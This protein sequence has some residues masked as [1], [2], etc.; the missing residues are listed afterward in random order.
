VPTSARRA[1]LKTSGGGGFVERYE[2][3]TASPDLPV[4]RQW[5]ERNPGARARL[6][7]TTE[8]GGG[9]VVLVISIPDHAEM[10]RARTEI[11][12]LVQFPE[13]LRFRR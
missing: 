7:E 1:F 3:A 11:P 9:R 4:V 10:V 5:V 2:P 13:L 6:T 12:P 8:H